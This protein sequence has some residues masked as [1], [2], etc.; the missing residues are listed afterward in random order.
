MHY[1]GSTLGCFKK[2]ENVKKLSKFIGMW[3]IDNGLIVSP[4]KNYKIPENIWHFKTHVNTIVS[5][6]VGTPPLFLGKAPLSGYAP[7]SE[8][9]LKSY[10]PL[11]ESHPKWCMEIVRNTLKW[12]CYVLYYAKSITTTKT[13]QMPNK[14]QY[15]TCIKVSFSNQ[16]L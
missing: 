7:L 16:N 9:N 11:F 3:A 13:Y 6:R 12:R 1:F 2:I 14:R 5:S 4:N 15:L 8:A 10:P